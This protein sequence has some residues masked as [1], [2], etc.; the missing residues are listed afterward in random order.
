MSRRLL[1]CA[2]AV[3]LS[4]VGTVS[5]A[6]SAG[7]VTVDAVAASL[8]ERG[9]KATLETYF[10]CENY[11]GS[12]YPAIAAGSGEW[13]ALAEK[14]IAHSDACYTEGI[15]AA[16]GEAMRKAPRRVL[17]LVDK[18]PALGAEHICLP[19]ISD[20]QAIAAQAQELRKSRRAILAVKDRALSK[21]RG[22]CLRFIRD[23]EAALAARAAPAGK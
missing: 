23:V 19:F 6:G 17:P 15:Q 13:V 20:E 7:G 9:P 12:A 8:A 11:D 1:R 22:A 10:S 4:I 3:L 5:L 21:P 16:L 14:M 2:L 18:T